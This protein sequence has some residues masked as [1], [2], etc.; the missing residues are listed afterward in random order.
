MGAHTALA[1]PSQEARP[2][3]RRRSPGAQRYSL[4]AAHRYPLE[5]SARALRRRLHLPS[6][7]GCLGGRWHLGAHLAGLLEHAGRAGQAGVGPSLPRWQLRPG[8]KG[9]DAVGYG[10]RGKGS[11]RHLIADGAGRPLAFMLTGAQV[12]EKRVALQ[13]VD[14]VRVKRKQGRPKQRPKQLAADAGYDSRPLRR[15][16]RRRGITPSIPERQQHKRQ[17]RR[18]GRPAKVHPVSGQRWKV[19]RAFAWLNNWRRLATRYERRAR[20]YRAFLTIACFM[21][22]LN[23]ILR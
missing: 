17:R 5:R 12:N 14:R 13:T 16:L 4:R 23:G 7:L 2:P 3:A 1:P 18:R 10:R 15:E 21:V 22:C 9:G 8:Q 11:P 20:I 6:A 19:E